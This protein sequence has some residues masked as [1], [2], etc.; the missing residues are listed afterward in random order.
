MYSGAPWVFWCGSWGAQF[1]LSLSSVLCPTLPMSLG[2]SFL[3]SPS[4]FSNVYC[5]TKQYLPWQLSMKTFTVSTAVSFEF[6]TP[7]V[8]TKTNAISPTVLSKFTHR[9][10]HWIAWLVVVIKMFMSSYFKSFNVL[11][12]PRA[13]I[14]PTSN[15]V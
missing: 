15:L 8:C 2:C 5:F 13:G 7:L 9:L 6:H 14:Q 1:C 11:L 3:I 12:L 10:L 4:I